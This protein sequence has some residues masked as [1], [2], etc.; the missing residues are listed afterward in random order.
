MVTSE[1]R[2]TGKL[3]CMM[4]SIEPQHEE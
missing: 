2:Q 4:L 3:R 1:N